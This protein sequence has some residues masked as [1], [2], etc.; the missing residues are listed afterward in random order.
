MLF[1]YIFIKKIVFQISKIYYKNSIV[2]YYLL[3]YAIILLVILI[4]QLYILITIIF[5]TILLPNINDLRTLSLI[6]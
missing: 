3:F 6:F 5:L 4:Y 2:K 1:N